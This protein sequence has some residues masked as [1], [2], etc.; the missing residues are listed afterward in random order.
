M[1]TFVQFQL[2]N[3]DNTSNVN[4]KLTSFGGAKVLFKKLEFEQNVKVL[5]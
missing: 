5:R 4:N 3:D 2:K 1:S